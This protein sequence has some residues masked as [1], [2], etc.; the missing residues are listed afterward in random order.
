MI[1]KAL[2]LTKR[3]FSVDLYDILDCSYIGQSKA[4]EIQTSKNP[5]VNKHSVTV[6]YGSLHKVNM[7]NTVDCRYS[8]VQYGYI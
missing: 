8:A 4:F 7:C 2:R 5:M 1:H 3:Y 6:I